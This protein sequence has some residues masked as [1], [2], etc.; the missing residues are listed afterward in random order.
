MRVDRKQVLWVGILLAAVV[1]SAAPDL[2]RSQEKYPAR[3]IDIIIPFAPG[4]GTDLSNRIAAG[5]LKQKW[6]TPVNVISKPG[7]NTVPACLEVYSSKPDGYLILGDS[8]PSSSL[9]SVVVKQLPFKVKDRTFIGV[10][11]VTAMLLMV[12]SSSPIKTLQDAIAE[13]KKDPASFTWTSLGGASMQ[14]YVIRQ[15]FKATGIDVVKTKPIMSQG[16]SQATTLTAGGH[17]KLGSGTTSG[18]LS[19]FKGGMVRPLG[20]TG[21]SRHPDFPDVPTFEELGYPT[22]TAQNWNGFSGPPNLPS[23]I[24]DAWDKALQEMVKDPEVITKLANI[25]STPLY[26]N[27]TAAKEHV[28]KEAEEV[29]KLFSLK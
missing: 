6:G 10:A 13:A 15:F 21:K 29:E 3:A 1:T 18:I 5:F 11:N 28:M 2:A 17:V 25:G 22:V 14:D 16:G 26:M 4:A 23:S 7:G 27:G 9:L 12:P 8:V 20:V 24:V 19:A